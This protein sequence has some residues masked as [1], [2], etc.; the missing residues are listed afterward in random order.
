L[1]V[2]MHYRR[3]I[4]LMIEPYLTSD[5]LAARWGLSP[6]TI[7]GQRARGI[8]PVYYTIPR[9]SA[10][11]GASRVRYPLSQVLAFEEANSITP[12]N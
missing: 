1:S 5:Q 8:G 7:K 11:S 10:P 3:L 2:R 12:L 6:A 4:H 9:I